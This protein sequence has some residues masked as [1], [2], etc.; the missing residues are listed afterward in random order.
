MVTAGGTAKVPKMLQ[1]ELSKA[2]AYLRVVLHHRR[3]E[4]SSSIQLQAQCHRDARQLHRRRHRRLPVHSPIREKSSS[5]VNKQGNE[6]GSCA[7]LPW[8]QLQRFPLR[9]KDEQIRP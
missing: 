1:A 5:V 3:I 2:E 7:R 8:L 4:H 6:D 9:Y